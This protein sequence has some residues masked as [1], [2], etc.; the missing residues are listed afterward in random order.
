MHELVLHKGGHSLQVRFS[1]GALLLTPSCSCC[2]PHP[3]SHVN[4]CACFLPDFQTSRYNHIQIDIYVHQ[5]GNKLVC[6][7]FYFLNFPYSLFIF[8]FLA[9][10][11]GLWDLVPWPGIKPMPPV[12][13]AWSLSHWTIREVPGHYFLN[14]AWFVLIYPCCFYL[15]LYNSFIQQAFKISFLYTNHCFGL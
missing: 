7:I 12:L 5:F 2:L 11:H 10:W 13:G 15:P 3:S 4:S 8:N 6:K 14:L 1:A 9:I